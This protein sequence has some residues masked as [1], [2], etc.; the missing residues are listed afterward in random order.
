MTKKLLLI[1]VALLPFSL[2]Q[3]EIT[4]ST[5]NIEISKDCMKLEGDNIQVKSD[6]CKSDK[7]D[8]DDKENRSVHGDD[9]PGQGHDK[10]HGKK[11]KKK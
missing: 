7:F 9:N 5:D 4:V 6:D 3:A 11:D 2:A 8:K 1:A 10:D